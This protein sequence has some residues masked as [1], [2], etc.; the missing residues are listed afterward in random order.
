MASIEFRV[1]PLRTLPFSS[2]VLAALPCLAALAVLLRIA[3]QIP[4]L[5]LE[6]AAWCAV[7]LVALLYQLRR[8][9]RVFASTRELA[10]GAEDEALARALRELVRTFRWGGLMV[11]LIALGVL[12]AWAQTH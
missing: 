9:Q 8:I 1:R 2:A 4:W 7:L 12:W 11:L 5:R 10:P 3:W 6:A